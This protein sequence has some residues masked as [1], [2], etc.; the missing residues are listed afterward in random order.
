MHTESI[1]FASHQPA[2]PVAAA[3][4]LA[5][6]LLGPSTAMS[7]LWS[8]IRRLAPHLRTVLLTG[9]SHSGQEAVAR[10]LLDLSPQPRRPFIV[11]SGA[12]AED[13]LLRAHLPESLPL[14]AFLFF[15]EVDDLSHAAQLNLLR[16][17]RTR[18][19]FPL[20]VAAATTEDLRAL[21]SVGRFSAEL[22]EA[23]GA[24]RIPIPALKERAED[25]PMLLSQMI[26]LRCQGRLGTMPQLSDTLLR[27]A[28]EY[29]WPDNLRELSD[30]VDD[31]VEGAD[32]GTELT[33][34]D[35]Q[36]TM[37]AQRFARPLSTPV[38]ML[39]LDTIMQEHI[40]SVLRACRGNKLR[41]SEVLGI[42]R[43]TLYRML[44]AAAGVTAMPL[45]N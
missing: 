4:E 21:V 7:Q 31:L 36:K 27:T 45:A 39:K 35:W 32:S 2:P 15:P 44:E 38:R 19:A 9:R 30:V 33:L 37:A 29:P 5:L 20:S 13:Q 41:A 1:P 43:S 14:D 10:L 23:L 28:M 42:S 8:Q 18:R 40:Y 12:E 3:A 24:V 16:L 34:A 11:L 22:A 6:T 25:L 26:A 17:L